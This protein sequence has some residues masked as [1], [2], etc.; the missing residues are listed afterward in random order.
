MN[1]DYL[2]EL[3]QKFR[4]RVAEITKDA[5]N[6][7]LTGEKLTDFL[8]DAN[9]KTVIQAEKRTR[10]FMG[11]LYTKGMNLSHLTFTMDRNL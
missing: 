2:T 6:T 10:D 11:E 5:L 9:Q 1:L 8:T 4:S 7:G 3:K